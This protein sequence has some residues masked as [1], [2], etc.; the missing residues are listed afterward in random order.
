VLAAILW[1][2]C[3]ALFVGT[4][5]AGRWLTWAAEGSEHTRR[6]LHRFQTV[7]LAVL[8]LCHLIR[9]VLLA[10]SMSGSTQFGQSV[11]LVPTI[12]SSTRQGGLWFAN[13]LALAA[14]VAAQFLTKSRAA[15]L[16][17]WVAIAA[18]CLVAATRAAS[19]HASEEGDFS[20]AEISQFL[21]LLATSVWAGAILVSAFLV[22]PHWPAIG[23][24]TLWNYAR[25][26]SQTVT[27]AL[28]VLVLT[29]TGVDTAWRSLHGAIGA[30]WSHPWGKIL[31]VKG[32][33]V[34]LAVLLGS[35]TRFRCV[36]C[37]PSSERAA[38]M[39]KLLRSEAVVRS[40]NHGGNPLP[41]RGACQH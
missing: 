24:S 40:R 38:A 19:S 10:S 27:W 11:A 30:L 18:L 5:L 35:L 29:L 3:Y 1:D 14:L 39:T 37:P 16:A 20:L 26:L 32:S 13:S 9:P 25:R 21:H 36:R 7:S 2:S 15:S 41:V 28:A 17:F 34:G 4:V 23:A 22:V 8:V 33:L 31:L 12:L 6:A